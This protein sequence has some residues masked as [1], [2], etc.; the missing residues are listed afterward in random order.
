MR[1]WCYRQC[2][3]FS[4]D[5]KYVWVG[6]AVFHFQ[7][8]PF[9]N[10][11]PMTAMWKM[12]K[13]EKNALEYGEMWKSSFQCWN[14]TWD[15][16]L[17]QWP[18]ALEIGVNVNGLLSLAKWSERVEV[19]PALGSRQKNHFSGCFLHFSAVH[20]AIRPGLFRFKPRNTWSKTLECVQLWTCFVAVLGAGMWVL[21]Y[22]GEVTASA[23][24]SAALPLPSVR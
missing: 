4:F 22:R 7:C 21:H 6:S 3:S 24:F 12:L 8:A 9:L 11:N 16:S 19:S 13:E 5:V 20:T 2:R 10:W 14:S 17:L 23:D 18:V 15:G 1:R